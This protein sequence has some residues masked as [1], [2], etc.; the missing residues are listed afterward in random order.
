MTRRRRS[1][2]K[3]KPLPE[4]ASTGFRKHSL[5]TT[6]GDKRPLDE[7]HHVWANGS[8]YWSYDPLGH[9]AYARLTNRLDSVP[10][11]FFGVP[12][13]SRSESTNAHLQGKSH[14]TAQVVA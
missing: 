10:P 1:R 11:R 6:S 7:R 9:R 2:S 14:A 3:Q 5:L 4:S 12:R 8:A 13:C